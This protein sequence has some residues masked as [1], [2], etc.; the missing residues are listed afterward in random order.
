M[1]LL[2]NT[3]IFF[4]F[5]KRTMNLFDDKPKLS[6]K[7]E[8]EFF[9]SGKCN[10]NQRD[11]ATVYL[12]RRK[13]YKKWK[14]DEYGNCLDTYKGFVTINLYEKYFLEVESIDYKV[15]PYKYEINRLFKNKKHRNSHSRISKKL[16][17][18]DKLNLDRY[19]RLNKRLSLYEETI[20]NN[21]DFRAIQSQELFSHV[22]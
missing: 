14:E 18:K 13:N 9:I 6:N 16:T 8:N 2:N 7:L 17:K 22:R 10:C 21:F 15:F 20:K 1:Y 3:P 5:F 4:E 12:K 19:F 11:C